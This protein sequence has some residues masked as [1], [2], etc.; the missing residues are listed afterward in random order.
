MLKPLAKEI[1]LERQNLDIVVLIIRIM[2]GLLQ[3]SF[4]KKLIMIMTMKVVH[5]LVTM[6]IIFFFHLTLPIISGQQ[7]EKE[8]LSGVIKPY[9]L[10]KILGKMSGVLQ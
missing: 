6:E 10:V 7:K 9:M 2:G 3:K 4:P 8:V 1:E 5:L